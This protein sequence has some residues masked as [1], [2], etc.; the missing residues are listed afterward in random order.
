MLQ[1][2]QVERVVPRFQAFVDRFPDVEALA[3]AREE[4]VLEA[5]SGLG[6]Y[7]RAR[8]LHRAA[9]AIRDA[10]SWPST[11]RELEALPGVGPYTAAAVASL[12]FGEACPVLDGNVLRVGA[13]VLALEGE[14]RSTAGRTAISNLVAALIRET[15]EAAAVNEALMELG[16][17]LC[18]PTAPECSCCPL[19]WIC[20][21]RASGHPERWPEPRPVRP[22][23][24]LHW[25]AAVIVDAAGLWL[26]RPLTDGPILR[27]LWLPP[28]V[29][30]SGASEA[31]MAAVAAAPLPVEP[32]GWGVLPAVR[33][34]ITHRR[35]QV[36]PVVLR[37]AHAR[38]VTG[39]RW[40]DPEHP[41]VPTSSLLGKLA[42]RVAAASAER[43]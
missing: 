16:A 43:G 24:R 26:L 25:A 34:S 9:R 3:G 11:R 32:S 5:W 36:H 41:G 20:R 18:R 2:T 40:V 23:E 28:L 8:W 35:I 10:G 4:D 42:A 22:V 14:A 17:T 15:G 39:C 37:A 13:R 19:A 21:A 27:G 7:R 12:A 38:G 1:Q 6:Y 33:H 29:P 31:E 30:V